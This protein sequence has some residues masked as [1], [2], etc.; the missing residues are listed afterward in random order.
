MKSKLN[1]KRII[2]IVV[3]V[4]LILS[5][6]ILPKTVLATSTQSDNLIQNGDFETGDITGF[7]PNQNISVVDTSSTSGVSINSYNAFFTEGNELIKEISLP[8]GDYVWQFDV[9]FKSNGGYSVVFDVYNGL[10]NNNAYGS[11]TSFGETTNISLMNLNTGASSSAIASNGGGNGHRINVNNGTFSYKVTEKFTI[12]EQKTVY[13]SIRAGA[14][15]FVYIDNMTL[16]KKVELPTELQNGDFENG[17]T[18]WNV[19]EGTTA[20][21]FD[22]VNATQSDAHSIN[23]TNNAGYFVTG[24]P[25]T[26]LY[27]GVKLAAGEYTWKFHL[28]LCGTHNMVGAYTSKSGIGTG[29]SLIT[30]DTF[31]AVNDVGTTSAG[32]KKDANDY[33]ISLNKDNYHY[34]VTYVFTLTEE[35]DV[36]FAIR[37]NGGACQYIDNMSLV[38]TPV[39]STKLVNGDF[40][41]RDLTGFENPTDS[42]IK[43]VNTAEVSGDAT[44]FTGYAAYMP[45]GAADKA[46]TLLQKVKLPAGRYNWSFDVDLVVKSG[47]WNFLFGVYTDLANTGVGYGSNKSIGTASGT[48]KSGDSVTNITANGKNGFYISYGGAATLNANLNVEFTL[49]EETVVYFDIRTAATA[50]SYIDNMSLVLNTELINGDFETRD[51]TGFENTNDSAI[52]VVNTA[53]VSG[54]ATTFT[55]YAAYMPGGAADKANTLLQKVKLPAGRYNWSFDVDLVVK[56]GG[57]NFLFGVYTD[58]A[59]TGVGYGSNKSIGTASGTKKSGDSVTNITANGTNGFYIS[60]G[61]AATLNANLNVEFTLTEE[62]VVYLDIRTAATARSYIDN[63]TLKVPGSEDGPTINTLNYDFEN[64]KMDGISFIASSEGLSKSTEISDSYAHGGT[65]SLK[66]QAVA[67]KDNSI[68]TNSSNYQGGRFALPISVEKNKYY[69]TTF[70]I[71][72]DGNQSDDSVAFRISKVKNGSSY[73]NSI[74][75]SNSGPNPSAELTFNPSTTDWKMNTVPSNGWLGFI[76]IMNTNTSDSNDWVEVSVKYASNDLEEVY[77]EFANFYRKGTIFYLDDVVTT[78][79]NSLLDD[80]LSYDFETGGT[81]ELKYGAGDSNSLASTTK[82]TDEEKHS[83]Q[84]SLVSTAVADSSVNGA[85]YQGGTLAIPIKN[86]EKN[87]NYRL[88]FWTKIKG[89]NVSDMVAFRV[90]KDIPA[91]YRHSLISS[92]SEIFYSTNLSVSDSSY[93]LGLISK[94]GSGWAGFI[95][96]PNLNKGSEWIQISVDFCVGNNENVYL[97]FANFFKKGTTFYVDDIKFEEIGDLRV[98]PVAKY[99]DENIIFHI[100]FEEEE[101]IPLNANGTPANHYFKTDKYAHGGKYSVYWDSN[102][103]DGWNYLYYT[104]KVGN[105]CYDPV[106]E[107][108][109]AYRFSVWVYSVGPKASSTQFAYQYPG[110]QQTSVRTQ[111]GKWEQIVIDFVT[112][113]DQTSFPFKIC[114]AFMRFGDTYQYIDDIKLEKLNCSITAIDTSDNYCEAFFNKVENGNFEDDLKKS[115]WDTDSLNIERIKASDNDPS[116]EGAYYAHLQGN[117]SFLLKLELRSVYQYKFMFSYRAKNKS[118]LKIGI[119]DD[120]GNELKLMNGV[121]GNI[122]GLLS[123]VITNGEWKRMGYTFLT[124]A[125]GIVYL[126]IEGTDLDIDLDEIS[127]Y[128]SRLTYELDPNTYKGLVYKTPSD[129]ELDLPIVIPDVEIEVPTEDLE[130]PVENEEPLEEPLIEKEENI[131][132]KN[133]DTDSNQSNNLWLVILIAGIAVVVAACTVIGIIIIKKRSKNK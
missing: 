24:G 125:S 34:T 105:M 21:T 53:K 104:D 101:S 107:P 12:T 3:S 16:T 15:D 115:I 13:L 82:R 37:G 72:I 69:K 63:M 113:E 95:G 129:D 2:S 5:I 88:S 56:S 132:D 84:Y 131:P 130:I 61:S 48:K 10:A 81:G 44:T 58:L 121:E 60:Y 67:D 97:Q 116:E 123:P 117:A 64:G 36:Y 94:P 96:I 90:S 55:G 83:G 118:N 79:I 66:S 109:T 46:N 77:L 112:E 7:R 41:T 103:N 91:T 29:A 78:E 11:K 14:G 127:V 33:R 27:Q 43:V 39:I 111:A 22:I 75:T 28:D 68:S 19:T 45:G 110:M 114:S 120:N 126:K 26:W 4:S 89:D 20:G 31:T 100:T 38:K 9:N 30:A 32:F 92:N 80:S 70:W 133:T 59:N 73:T 35:T 122:S 86:L 108:S 25:D 65:K 85:G 87:K 18:G 40:E 62:T 74:I 98:P 99:D 49:T 124:P 50:R 93:K 57:W 128:I 106:L 71:R 8:S 42:A 47:G 54:D 51:L 17:T 76:Q 102:H 23:I 52:Q 6:L 1:Y 119:L